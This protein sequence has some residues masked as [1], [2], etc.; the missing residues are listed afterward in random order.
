MWTNQW[1]DIENLPQT[2]IEALKHYKTILPNVQTLLQLFST[3]PVT[4][5]TPEGTFLFL[6]E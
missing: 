3:L 1:K 6:K 4:S 5:A 2:T